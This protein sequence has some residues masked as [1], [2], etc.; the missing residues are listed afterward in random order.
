MKLFVSTTGT[1]ADWI[2]KVIDQFPEGYNE[3][4]NL[5]VQRTDMKGYKMLLRYG[6]MRGKYRNSLEFPQAFVPNHITEVSFDLLDVYHTFKKGHRIVI[7]IQSSLFPIIDRNPQQFLNIYNS[8]E[9]NFITAKQKVY[10]SYKYK[11]CVTF[12]QTEY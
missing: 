6:V 10:T 2:V 7:Q 12:Y 5:K 4:K 3:Y 9:S 1:D 11:S 8:E